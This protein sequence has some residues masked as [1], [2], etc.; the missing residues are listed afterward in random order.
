MVS[1]NVFV[2]CSCKRLKL[3][4]FWYT[5]RRSYWR[6]AIGGKA[7][8]FTID[9]C[10][11]I[12]NC[13]CHCAPQRWLE[14]RTHIQSH[15]RQYQSLDR[16]MGGRD[17][18]FSADVWRVTGVTLSKHFV[19]CCMFGDFC[20][21]LCPCT[22]GPSHSS[23]C[24]KLSSNIPKLY[25][26]EMHHCMVEEEERIKTG[27]GRFLPKRKQ[28]IHAKCSLHKRQIKGN[29]MTERANLRKLKTDGIGVD[30][31]YQRTW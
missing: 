15:D 2:A 21:R 30:H 16:C 5:H 22:T 20:C 18:W 12:C 10:F 8:S 28:A 7:K 27:D 4:D 19:F 25:M 13:D 29:G 17:D 9:F 11:D 3:R 31:G 23:T 26:T 1:W 14:V 24:E 6:K